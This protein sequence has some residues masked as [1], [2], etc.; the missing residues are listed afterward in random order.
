MTT[1]SGHR[2]CDSRRRNPTSTPAARAAGDEETTRFA[3][4]TAAGSSSDTPAATTDQ[5]GHRTTKVRTGGDV[6]LIATSATGALLPA[7]RRLRHL[8]RLPGATRARD[9][10]GT[11]P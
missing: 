3:K 11:R 1:S 5:S 9:V 6:M 4:N 7:H 10:L 8:R 2:L